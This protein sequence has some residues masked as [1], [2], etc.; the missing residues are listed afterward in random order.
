MS[1]KDFS[2]IPASGRVID[3]IA[4]A[5]ADGRKPRRTPTENEAAADMDAMQTQGKKGEK[6]PRMNM[7]FAPAVYDYIETMAKARGES[8]TA[9]V[10]AV[11]AKHKDEHEDIYKKAVDFTAD[12]R[13]SL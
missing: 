5:T 6:L 1:K 7:A 9:F 3:A 8:M 10:N 11:L 2:Q 13:N 4:E 12:F